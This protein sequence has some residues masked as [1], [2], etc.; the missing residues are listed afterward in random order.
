M[1]TIIAFF[2]SIWVFLFGK[3]AIEFT[4]AKPETLS[5]KLDKIEEKHHL[6]R[7]GPHVPPHNNRKNTRGRYTQFTPG[8]RAIYHDVVR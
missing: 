6:R 1:K 2:V 5:D 4:V 7:S 8:G 3:K